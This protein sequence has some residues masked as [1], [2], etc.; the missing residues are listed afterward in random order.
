MERYNVSLH[1]R[2]NEENIV[3]K[4]ST[5]AEF[6]RGI[7]DSRGDVNDKIIIKHLTAYISRYGVSRLLKSEC[8]V[9]SSR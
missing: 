9:P 2:T 1:G 5:A 6:L 8:G 4:Y 3:E 7:N